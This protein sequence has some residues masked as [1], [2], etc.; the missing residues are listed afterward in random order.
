MI[1]PATAADGKLIEH[2]QPRR[3]FSR[4]QNSRLGSGNG[5]YEFPRERSD[6]AEPL[7]QV[8]DHALAGKNHPRI[9]TDHSNRLTSV[10]PHPVENFGMTGD[11]VMRDYSAIEC[12]I[13]VENTRNAA[14]AG[15][16][17]ILFRQ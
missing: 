1:L 16:N 7:Q 12:G 3:G 11:L 13:D 5:F 6:P 8:E 9:V 14:Q 17:A 10:Q 2:A 15:K 4:I